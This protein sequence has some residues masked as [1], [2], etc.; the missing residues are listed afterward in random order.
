MIKFGCS[1][2]F[3]ILQGPENDQEEESELSLTELKEKR[4]LEMEEKIR[5]KKEEIKAKLDEEEK[6]QKLI[7]ERGISWGLGIN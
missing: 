4:K 6:E 7:E 3:F 5:E 1:T 2:R